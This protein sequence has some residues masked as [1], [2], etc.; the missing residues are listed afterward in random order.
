MPEFRFIA[1]DTSGGK[2]QPADKEARSHAI[3]QGLQRGAQARSETDKTNRQAQDATSRRADLRG[4]FRLAGAQSGAEALRKAGTRAYQQPDWTAW[5]KNDR[6]KSSN[7]SRGQM[8][9]FKSVPRLKA[10]VMDPFNSLPIP[11]SPTIDSLAKYCTLEPECLSWCPRCVRLMVYLPGPSVV[12]G[13]SLNLTTVDKQRPW[14]PY[15]MQSELVMRATL[16][17]AAGFWTASLPSLDAR[18][19]IEGYRQKGEAMRAISSRLQT[20]ASSRVA[21][22]DTLVLAAVATLANVEESG[23]PDT[24]RHDY[25]LCRCINWVDVQV[26]SGLGRIPFFPTF[27]TLDQVVL[28]AHILHQ[29]VVPPLSDL[30]IEEAN[31]SATAACVHTILTLLRQAICAQTSD[32]VGADGIRILMGTADSCILN[33]LYGGAAGAADYR[34]APSSWAPTSS[35]T[36]P[37]RDVPPTSQLLTILCCRLRALLTELDE[38]PAAGVGRGALSLWLAFVGLVGSGGGHGAAA[39]SENAQWFAA[40][41]QTALRDTTPGGTLTEAGRRDLRTTLRSFLWEERHCRAV[42]DTLER[43]HSVSPPPD[44]EDVGVEVVGGGDE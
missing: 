4:R 27:H 23:G 44:A 3:K 19:Q 40:M 31:G 6:A 39:G 20:T 26:A 16:A 32:S 28:P 7:A 21:S 13:F 41:F 29:A 12:N 2:L 36:S 43:R 11:S 37:C 24:I 15:A 18:L 5:F 42:L 10:H 8:T 35:S 14:F 22:R 38:P 1:S 34:S 25:I 33:F 30:G 17:L 9:P